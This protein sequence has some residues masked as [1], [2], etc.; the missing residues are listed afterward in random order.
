MIFKKQLGHGFCD[1]KTVHSKYFI[2][3]RGERE[4]QSFSEFI[5]EGFHLKGKIP[6]CD[7]I[8]EH[9]ECHRVVCSAR[10]VS[11]GFFRVFLN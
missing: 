1:Q 3:M 5:S 11:V 8:N 2:D 6:H 4:K 10:G 7:K 9:A